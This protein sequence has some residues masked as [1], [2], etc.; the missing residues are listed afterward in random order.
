MLGGLEFGSYK[1][2]SIV[3]LLK[4]RFFFETLFFYFVA[5]NLKGKSTLGY[6]YI[7]KDATLCSLELCIFN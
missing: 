3:L 7:F 5:S 4:R 1:K 6:Q 2:K